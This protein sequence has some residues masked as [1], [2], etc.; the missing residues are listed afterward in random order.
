MR[1]SD[2][3]YFYPVNYSHIGPNHLNFGSNNEDYGKLES[4]AQLNSAI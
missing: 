4:M 3:Q 1:S 2:N